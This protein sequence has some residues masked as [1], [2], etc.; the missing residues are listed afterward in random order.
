MWQRQWCWLLAVGSVSDDRGYHVKEFGE[1]GDD[2]DHHECGYGEGI[3]MDGIRCQD[4]AARGCGAF[5][6]LMTRCATGKYATQEICVRGLL[7]LGRA[8]GLLGVGT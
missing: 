2:G 1:G 4:K 8:K 5:G 7:G 3:K 6:R